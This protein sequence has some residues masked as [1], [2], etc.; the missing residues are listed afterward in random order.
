[1]LRGTLRFIGARFPLFLPS[2]FRTIGGDGVRPSTFA[3]LSALT[4]GAAW[5]SSLLP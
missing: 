1:M 2:E 3:T 5:R 4:R